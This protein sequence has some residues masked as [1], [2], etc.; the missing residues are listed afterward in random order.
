MWNTL[1]Q[2]I[3]LEYYKQNYAKYQKELYEVSVPPNEIQGGATSLKLLLGLDVEYTDLPEIYTSNPVQVARKI[4]DDYY[5]KHGDIYTYVRT[6]IA[7]KELEIY[8]QTRK[9]ATIFIESTAKDTFIQKDINGVVMKFISPKLHMISMLQNIYSPANFSK[10][11]ENIELLKKLVD[12]VDDFVEYKPIEY[13]HLHPIIHNKVIVYSSPTHVIAIS[14]KLIDEDV[15]ILERKSRL[16]VQV[17]D[18]RLPSEYFIKKITAKIDNIRYTIYNS[19]SYELIPYNEKVINNKVWKIGIPSVTARYLMI[20]D[21][22][23]QSLVKSGVLKFGIYLTAR[24]HIVDVFDEVYPSAQFFYGIQQ[25]KIHLK[26]RL[27]KAGQQERYYSLYFPY[28]AVNKDVAK[29]ELS[30]KLLQE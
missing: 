15:Q 4:A 10:R 1:A 21:N 12:I 11:S 16:P 27:I 22:S 14:D 13:K 30:E 9:I 3:V 19:A 24:Q 20:E 2:N 26:R 8:R 29:D 17:H 18:V 23:T 28:I 7:N 25:D 5:K 6:V